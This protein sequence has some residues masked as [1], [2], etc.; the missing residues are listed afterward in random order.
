MISLCEEEKRAMAGVLLVAS[1]VSA[2]GKL[3]CA[4][5]GDPVEG[6]REYRVLLAARTDTW[7]SPWLLKDGNQVE[8]ERQRKRT[9]GCV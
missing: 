7:K 5:Q 3:S 9:D 1:C 8:G 6:Y 4:S 2:F